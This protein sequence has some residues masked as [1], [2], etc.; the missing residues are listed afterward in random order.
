MLEIHNVPSS[1]PINAVIYRLNTDKLTY[2]QTSVICVFWDRS[3]NI[4]GKGIN[5]SL[6]LSTSQYPED[7]RGTYVELA[8]GSQYEITDTL[9][10][11]VN[12]PDRV[13]YY[14]CVLTKLT[15]RFDI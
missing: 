9:L 13:P 8:N 5:Y 4:E 11:G 1:L 12:T 7:P 10:T 14:S 2:T 3:G 6:Q 15:Q